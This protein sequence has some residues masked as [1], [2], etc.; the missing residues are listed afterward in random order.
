MERCSRRA[1]GF[2][3]SLPLRRSTSASRACG[4]AAAALRP[5]FGTWIGSAAP[6]CWCV[7]SCTNRS[8][9]FPNGSSCTEKT[10]IFACGCGVLALAALGV[11]LIAVSLGTVGA[12]GAIGMVALILSA[13]PFLRAL[14][15]KQLDPFEPIYLFVV[16]LALTMF[17]RGLLDLTFGS[18]LL[19]PVLDTRSVQFRQLMGLVFGYSCLFLLALY[20]GYYS[21]LGELLTRPLP[22]IPTIHLSK[23]YV[24]GLGVLSLLMSGFAAWVLY[25]RIGGA[26]EVGEFFAATRQGGVCWAAYWLSFVLVGGRIRY[27]HAGQPP[28]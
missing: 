24:W 21:R 7:A 8:A 25:G 13:Y 10:S 14:P 11:A 23:R 1:S 27:R 28:D 12:L 16:Y 4:A 26:V 20:V 18:P 22:R 17:A 6:S 5:A 3:R 2:L 9:C 19:D 15:G